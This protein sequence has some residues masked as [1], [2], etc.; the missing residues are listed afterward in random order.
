MGEN[1]K[2]ARLTGRF[3][4]SMVAV[5]FS[6]AVIAAGVAFAVMMIVVVAA[7]I[8]IECQL[9]GQQG[10]HSSIGAAGDSTVELYACGCQGHL[11]TAA[12][13]AADQHIC[14]QGGQNAGQS[15]VAAAVGIDDMG[16]NDFAI[17]YI[18]DLKLFRV[19]EMLKDLAVF[20]GNCNSHNCDS[21]L[22]E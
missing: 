22:R 16:G 17:L 4:R 8:G 14:V 5:M 15:T 12:D 10:F 20:V 1:E 19:A 21:F 18:I 2:T 6:A 7:D 11:G 9:S 3:L 13:T